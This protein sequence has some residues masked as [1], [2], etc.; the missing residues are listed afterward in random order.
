MQEEAA[1][2]LKAIDP[3]YAVFGTLFLLSNQLEAVGN[4]FLG[5]L[6]T[7]QWFL[8][9]V[10]S[11]FFEQPPTLGELAAQMGSSHQNVKQLALRLQQKGFVSIE[12]DGK[13]ARALRVKATEKLQEYDEKTN[14]PNTLFI[15]R[16][17]DGF[18]RQQAACLLEN[19]LQLCQ[20][21]Q[22]IK[23]DLL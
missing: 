20:N 12:K 23:E 10:L 18:D 22:G 15:N 3:R 17:F 5:E 2:K 13:D 7:K 4:R 6:T 19:L 14:G 21:I 11:T 8:L 1:N 9:A 16:L